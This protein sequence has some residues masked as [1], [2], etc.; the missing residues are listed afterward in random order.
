MGIRNQPH[1]GSGSPASTSPEPK[2][3][4]PSPGGN[5]AGQL[6]LALRIWTGTQASVREVVGPSP[7][8]SWLLPQASLVGS[9][10]LKSSNPST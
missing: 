9:S 8:V 7:H 3:G 10:I 5:A 4:L 2:Q 1:T 6:R